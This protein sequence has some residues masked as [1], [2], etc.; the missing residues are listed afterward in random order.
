MSETESGCNQMI[1]LMINRRSVRRYADAQVPEQLLD[2]VL[3]AGLYAPTGGNHQYTRFIAIQSSRALEQLNEIVRNNFSAREIVEGCYQNKTIRKAKMEHYHCFY[4][5]PVLILVV[6]PSD[7]C[8]SMAD[9]ANALENMQL[10]ATSLGLGACW[11]NQIHWLTDDQRMR[12]Y[13]YGL[14]MEQT[15]SVFGSI[16]IGFPANQGKG[17][18]IRPERKAGR[19]VKI[20]GG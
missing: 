13:L 19:V 10:A 1:E 9:S 8:N 4:H 18:H 5:A 15:E 11:I 7:H 2:A 3:E 6:S 20:K 16:V 14:G 12:E 17:C